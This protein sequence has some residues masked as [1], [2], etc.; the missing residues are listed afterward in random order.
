MASVSKYLRGE[1][2]WA[3]VYQDGNPKPDRFSLETR[4]SDEAD[5]KIQKIRAK[6]TLNMPVDPE[7]EK[8]RFWQL[9]ELI[10]NNY[11]ARNLRSL[12]TLKSRLK[13][14]ILP[15]FGQRRVLGM[16]HADIEEYVAYRREQGA[17]N[18][19]IQR[20][21][22]AIERAFMLGARDYPLR[23][24][25]IRIEKIDEDNIRQGFF[26]LEQLQAVCRH[27][28]EH[29]VKPVQFDYIVGWRR[30]EVAQ[31]EKS[32]LDFHGGEIRLPAT[33]A[34][35]KDGRVF[36]MF[37]ELRA[38]LEPL[39][40]PSLR[41]AGTGETSKYVFTYRRSKKGPL[42][43]IGDFR[44]E[45]AKACHKAGLP[46]VVHFKKD[47]QGNVVRYKQGKK[48]GEPIIAKIDAEALFHDF[49]RTAVRNL[50]RRNI[51][52]QVA[53]QMTG[54]KT[55]SVFERYNIVSPR[56]LRNAADQLHLT[57]TFLGTTKADSEEES[58]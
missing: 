15:R 43:P 40:T 52:E 53:Q 20:E 4:D 23:I 29:Y 42:L 6:L 54:H 14:H 56:D 17:A 7:P 11:R 36:P 46:C 57:G 5:D 10:V 47:A 16:G 50:V 51:P 13:N 41:L 32:H 28:P 3:K 35:N 44:K 45:W 58:N 48:K 26:E 24:A 2:Y 55:R 39:N 25:P 37:P 9:C 33:I 12:K 30:S 1:I 19:T 18:G 27:L 8:L 38:L 34:K 22:D 31:L 21:V 49:R